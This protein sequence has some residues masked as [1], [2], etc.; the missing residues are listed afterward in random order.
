MNTIKLRHSIEQFF[1]EDI[2]DG[3]QTSDSIFERHQQG[4]IHF[5]A[6]ED[7][8]FAGGQVITTGY[9]ILSSSVACDVHVLDGEAVE[10]GQTIATANGPI[11]CLLTGERVILNLIQ[12]MSGIAT[13]THSAVQSLHSP[14]TRICDT[15]KTIPGLRMFD[16]YAVRAGGGY[17]HRNGLYDAV[18]IKDNHIAFAGSIEKAVQMVRDQVG[19]MVNIEVETE[20]AQ[21][22]LEAVELQVDCIMFDNCSPHQVEQFAGLVP[23][24]ITTEASGGITLDRLQDFRHTGVDYISL[25]CLTH[26]P[27]AL[28]ISARVHIDENRRLSE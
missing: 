13:L 24:S 7:G 26:S 27:K 12:R 9:N 15:R 21:Q 22:V 16:K 3:D 4:T 25:G 1:M 5:A 19:H 11:A 14:H 23:P 20:T 28:D 10:E 18:M 2:G 17:N 8:I 6:K